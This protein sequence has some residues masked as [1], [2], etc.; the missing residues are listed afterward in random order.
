MASL[1]QRLASTRPERVCLTVD[2]EHDCPP[3]LTTY[4]GIEEGVPRLLA[5]FADAGVPATFFT[6][7]DVARRYP[8]AI[9]R[10][11]AAGHEL[12]CH[13]DTHRRFSTMT[14][15]EARREIGEATAVLRR[16]APVVSFRAPNLDLPEAHLEILAAAGYRLDS[17]QGRHK[18]GSYFVAPTF[19]APLARV[20]ASMSPSVMR[21]PTAVRR[22]I[23]ERLEDPVVLFVH[24]WE[25]VDQRRSNLRLDNRFRTGDAALLCLRENIDYFRARGARFLRLA[26]LLGPADQGARRATLQDRP[27]L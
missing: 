21:L 23:A 14:L 3:H 8:Q 22:R 11:V 18:L 2:L 24:P 12:G 4:A 19:G 9:E 5:L 27:G 1:I 20:P 17:S 10:L 7:G 16:F 26:D 6:T 13:G 15:D 25:F